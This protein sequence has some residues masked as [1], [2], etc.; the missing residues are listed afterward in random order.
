MRPRRV[1][2]GW[3]ASAV[4]SA[5]CFRSFN[6]A[7]ARAPRMVTDTGDTITMPLSFNEAEARAPRMAASLP[8][9]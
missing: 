5:A 1:R 2:L 4:G 3:I 9:T 8:L 6:E 7:E